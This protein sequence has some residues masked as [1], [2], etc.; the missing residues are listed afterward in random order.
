MS[1]RS[2]TGLGAPRLLVPSIPNQRPPGPSLVPITGEGNGRMGGGGEVQ[3]GTRR[4][5]RQGGLATRVPWAGGRL[6][7]ESNTRNY[8]VAGVGWG[9]GGEERLGGT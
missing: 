3:G 5:K 6:G 4:E 8:R 1:R 9:G 7:R 2:L